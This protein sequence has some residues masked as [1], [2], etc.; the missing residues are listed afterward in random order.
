MT[1]KEQLRAD[2]P[3]FVNASEFA[4]V[5]DI[6]GCLCRAQVIEHTASKS[7]RLTENF[8]GL[9][10]DFTELYFMSEPYLKKHAKLPHKGD[11]MKVAGRRYDVQEVCAELGLCHVKLTAYRQSKPRLG[12]WR[13]T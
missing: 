9:H 12:D 11:L 8:E 6:D 10:G 2:L 7:Q 13:A 3:T 1:F 5:V 4:Q